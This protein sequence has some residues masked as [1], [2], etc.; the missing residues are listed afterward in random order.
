M[1]RLDNA[2]ADAA[3][4]NAIRS[5]HDVK[6]LPRLTAEWNLNR[7]YDTVVSNPGQEENDVDMFPIES[8][9]EPI[10]P[11]KGINKARINYS[12][13]ADSYNNPNLPR[14][15]VASLEDPYKYWVSPRASDVNGYITGAAPEVIYTSLVRTNKITVGIENSW[16]TPNQWSIQTTVDGG[17]SWQV[18]SSAPVIY[19]DG[20]AHLYWNGSGW[21]SS[22]PTAPT[23]GTVINGVR[24]VVNRLG[25]GIGIDGTPTLAR[26]RYG[27]A[28]TTGAGS[29]L[30]VIEIGAR[31]EMDLTDDLVEIGDTF[32]AGEANQVT[33]IGTITSNVADLVLWNGDNEF[34]SRMAGLLEPNVKVNLEYIYH[35]N[36]QTY[37]V[38]QF[39][40]FTENWNEKEDSTISVQLSDASKYLKEIYPVAAKYEKVTTAQAVYRLLDSVGFTDYNIVNWNS[41]NDFRIPVFWVDGSESIWEVFDQLAQATQTLIYFDGY[42]RLN[43]KSREN[44][45]DRN[46]GIDWT[47]RGETFGNELADIETL[48]KTGQFDSNVIKV[49]YK[50]ATW[51]EEINGHVQNTTVWSPED[52]VV[53]RSTPLLSSLD[54][55]SGN[56]AINPAQAVHWPYE[57]HIQ[58]EG[59]FIEYSGKWFNYR[60]G[61]AWKSVYVHN[62]QEYDYY[63]EL[64]GVNQRQ[65]NHFSGW[66]KIKERGVWNTDVQNHVPEAKG[67]SVKRFNH[68][69]GN[70]WG[71]RACW[72]WFKG[73]SIVRMASNGELTNLSQWAIATRGIPSDAP[74]KRFGTRFRFNGAALHH[75]AGIVF[76]QQA[77]G[78]GYYVEFRPTNTIERKDR[79]T[80]DEITIYSIHGN[81]FKKMKLNWKA[82]D[83]IVAD[84]W[85]DVEITFSPNGHWITVWLDGKKVAVDSI[86][87]TNYRHAPSGRFGMFI[88]GQTNVDFE[89]F[90]ALS[91]D[92]PE[93]PDDVSFLDRVRGA[94]VG[95]IWMRDRMY[96]TTTKSRWVKRKGK[97]KKVK[98]NYKYTYT[99][100]MDEFGPYV[101]EVREFDVKFDPAPVKSANL[102]FSNDWQVVCPVFRSDSH[103]AYFI[104]AN[105]SRTNAVVQGDDDATFAIAGQSVPQQLI[106]FG[107]NLVVAEDEQVEVRNEAQIR[108]RGEII[109]EIDSDWIQSEGAAQSIADWIAAHWAG[110][111][112]Q[113]ELTVFGN[114]LFEIGDL[115]GIEF[116]QKNMTTV[117]HQYFITGVQTEFDAGITTSLTL[118]RKN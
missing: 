80:E 118:Q 63:N 67:W 15:Y 24:I 90:Y 81:N 25:G 104:L 86:L 57:G 64:G 66:I 72:Q 34:S 93:L 41:K 8:I 82:P 32:D 105:A 37:P 2:A 75:R 62:Q 35:I 39:S 78:D 113:L 53:L 45:Y 100:F 28:Q 13:V 30:S 22:A 51:A 112:D 17:N 71:N 95:D 92:T 55:N 85:H 19:D 1:K 61:G 76:N 114:P 108:A 29:L 48:D 7:Y 96:R 117:T 16:A 23:N 111:S 6:A 42:G 54:E 14:Y 84:Q 68:K 79:N 40:M 70:S 21:S 83:L 47:L 36:G 44:A 91:D 110:G 59:E 27:M 101:H 58:V 46:R 43:V 3:V 77:N 88:R 52:S 109:A 12:T 38:Q 115:V 102:Y 65:W 26:T 50:K 89:Y 18:A 5:A 69:T 73:S 20:R 31:W 10:R 60:E 99:N 87:P 74:Y 94:F 11:S 116:A 9:V 97:K 98:R 106:V 4:R 56:F 49:S 107:R 33:P 103:G